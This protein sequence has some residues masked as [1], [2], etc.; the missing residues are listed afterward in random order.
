MK[1]DANVS[2]KQRETIIKFGETGKHVSAKAKMTVTGFECVLVNLVNP[3]RRTR[4]LL[5]CKYVG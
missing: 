3:A 4:Y 5:R 1:F 2:L